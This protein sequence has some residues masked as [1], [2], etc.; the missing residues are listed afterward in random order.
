MQIAVF[1]NSSSSF[2]PDWKRIV[3]Y[4]QEKVYFFNRFFK[5]KKKAPRFASRDNKA[6]DFF[7]Y[8]NVVQEE[9][10]DIS[11]KFQP[12]ATEHGGSLLQDYVFLIKHGYEP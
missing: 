3:K 10:R 2:T 1:I 4:T 6:Q 5:K 11:V 9:I 12:S 8:R 7:F